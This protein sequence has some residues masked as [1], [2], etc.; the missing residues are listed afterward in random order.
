MLFPASNYTRCVFSVV[1]DCAFY[2]KQMSPAIGVKAFESERDCKC[3]RQI[4]LVLS[5]IYVVS[6]TVGMSNSLMKKTFWL[7]NV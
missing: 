4:L 3:V 6:F 1:P 7:T 5:L 2:C